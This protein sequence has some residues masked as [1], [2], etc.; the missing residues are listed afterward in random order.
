MDMVGKC[1]INI[2]PGGRK[3]YEATGADKDMEVCTGSV[4]KKGWEL[5]LDKLT[6]WM[7]ALLK[8]FGKM[9]SVVFKFNK[10]SV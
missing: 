3:L 2:V 8:C 9:I 6:F 10:C 7:P 4:I 1:T 5:F